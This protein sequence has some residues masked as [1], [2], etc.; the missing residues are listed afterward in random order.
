MIGGLD[1]SHSPRHRVRLV[2]L[3]RPTPATG[4]Q[5]AN[6]FMSRSRTMHIIRIALQERRVGL[7]C[8]AG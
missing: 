2:N 1:L 5:P 7:S 4:Y 8:A 6:H 3:R